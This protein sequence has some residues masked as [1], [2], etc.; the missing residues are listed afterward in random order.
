MV[1][2]KT[3]RIV[4]VVLGKILFR[5]YVIVCVIAGFNEYSDT[6]AEK[7]NCDAADQDNEYF[8]PFFHKSHPYLC[9]LVVLSKK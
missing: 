5:L 1:I 9:I 3:G 6:Y 7:N 4:A 2:V 8:K